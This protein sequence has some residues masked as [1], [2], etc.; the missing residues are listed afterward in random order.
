MGRTCSI[1]THPKRLDIHKRILLAQGKGKLAI[2]NEFDVSRRA[3]ERHGKVCISSQ[4]QTHVKGLVSSHYLKA[5]D[6]VQTGIRN[7]LSDLEQ[8]KGS[9]VDRARLYTPLANLSK[10]L[11]QVTGEIRTGSEVNVQVNVLEEARNMTDDES[12]LKAQAYLQAFNLRHP[13]RALWVRPADEAEV[14]E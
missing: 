9:L 4:M 10:V 2:A 14:I 13:K 5:L 6:T 7:L 11:G 12:A 8:A 1:C 3:V